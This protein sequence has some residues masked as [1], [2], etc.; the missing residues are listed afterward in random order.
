MDNKKMPVALE[1]KTG[2][3]K[4]TAKLYKKKEKPSRGRRLWG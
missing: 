1:S 4:R 2:T 3:H